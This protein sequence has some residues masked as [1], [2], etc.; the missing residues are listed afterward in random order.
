MRR[1]QRITTDAGEQIGITTTNEKEGYKAGRE[2]G[3]AARKA[4]AR[5]EG[6]SNEG[7]EGAK[8]GKGRINNNNQH[9]IPE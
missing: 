3:L 9:R 1:E 7:K 2:R 5:G 8:E 4:G 6:Y